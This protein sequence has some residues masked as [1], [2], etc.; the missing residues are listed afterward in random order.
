MSTRK[1]LALEE[2]LKKLR[3][4]LVR[5]E[6]QGPGIVEDGNELFTGGRNRHA[7]SRTSPDIITPE[8]IA[9]IVEKATKIPV[10]RLLATDKSRLLHLESALSQQVCVCSYYLCLFR[11]GVEREIVVY[12]AHY[13]D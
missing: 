11:T 3:D 5:L 7:L 12:V 13:V 1:I 9:A 10:Q 6:H 8:S 4:E 2:D